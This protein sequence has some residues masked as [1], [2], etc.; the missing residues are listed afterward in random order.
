M[1][2]KADSYTIK[3]KLS[4]LEETLKL[5]LSNLNELGD[6]PKRAIEKQKILNEVLKLAHEQET[7]W[8][9]LVSDHEETLFPGAELQVRKWLQ[10]SPE[11]LKTHME[12]ATTTQLAALYATLDNAEGLQKDQWFSNLT[13]ASMLLANIDQATAEKELKKALEELNKVL[14]DSSPDE[15]LSQGR[16]TTSNSAW[17]YWLS[18]G[19]TSQTNSAMR[20]WQTI[21]PS[22]I[23]PE[24]YSD[25]GELVEGVESATLNQML[26]STASPENRAQVPEPSSVLGLIMAGSLGAKLR[27]RNRQQRP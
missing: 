14:E 11:A 12:T 24:E 21:N 18:Q 3:T 26:Y 2:K 19:R 20:Y 22:Y 8:N 27:H 7:R 6:G 15:L 4:S 5:K 23:S 25:E 17:R 16:T 13:Q 10:G 1:A 9:Q